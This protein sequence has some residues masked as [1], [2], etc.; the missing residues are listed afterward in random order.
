M[1][2]DYKTRSMDPV[3]PPPLDDQ[4]PE[5]VLA[6]SVR[7]AAAVSAPTLAAPRGPVVDGGYYVKTPENRLLVGPD[8]RRRCVSDR[9]G[10][11]IRH[12]VR[13]R[14][15]R[16]CWRRT[17]LGSP[18]PSYADAFCLARYEDPEYVSRLG[19]LGERGAVNEMIP[20]LGEGGTQRRDR[21]QLCHTSLE[22]SRSASGGSAGGRPEAATG[23]RYRLCCERPLSCALQP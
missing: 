1:L 21:L 15:W 23:R 9:R 12:H 3:F 17:S 19:Q 10:V 14:C 6:R 11:W 8:A 22:N 2:W 5:V 18:L 7:H 16:I 20:P 4:Y 13:L